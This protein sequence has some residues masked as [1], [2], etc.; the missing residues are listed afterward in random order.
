[1]DS[2]WKTLRVYH[3]LT[4]SLGKPYGSTTLPQP[5]RLLPVQTSKPDIF[6]LHKTG[7]FHFALTDSLLFVDKCLT[8]ALQ[9]K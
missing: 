4:T 7:H 2:L 3:I 6:I 5:L 1:M 9:Y 8:A